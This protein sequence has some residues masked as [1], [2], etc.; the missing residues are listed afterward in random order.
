MPTREA[1]LAPMQ[2]SHYHQATKDVLAI[3]GRDTEVLE[4]AGV[5][6]RNR[7][8]GTGMKPVPLVPLCLRGEIYSDW[9]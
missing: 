2:E 8:S 9:D 4:A 5:R 7:P 6:L 3:K 1:R